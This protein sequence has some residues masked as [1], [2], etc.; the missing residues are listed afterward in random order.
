[1]GRNLGLNFPEITDR[2][3]LADLY[4]LSGISIAAA[5]L[6]SYHRTTSWGLSVSLLALFAAIAVAYLRN[7]L[8]VLFL[9][10]IGCFLWLSAVTGHWSSP[11]D[12]NQM[13]GATGLSFIVML[14][15]SILLLAR[16][17]RIAK[18]ESKFWNIYLVVG[19]FGAIVLALVLSS[20]NFASTIETMEKG[21]AFSA[22]TQFALWIGLLAV[23][24]SVSF[25]LYVRKQLGVVEILLALGFLIPV[26]VW[27]FSGNSHLIDAGDGNA[28]IR[29]TAL[30]WFWFTATNGLAICLGAWIF[31]L[32][33][34]LYNEGLIN[35]AAT[36]GLMFIVTKYIDWFFHVAS[37]GVF[38]FGLGIVVLIAGFLVDRT[39]RLLL[40]SIR[41]RDSIGN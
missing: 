27:S 21:R 37:I 33:W 34:R 38:L 12:G 11:D 22:W 4:A 18:S 40:E 6:F 2:V 25:L 29:L 10:L 36:Y 26:V 15:I 31:N 23:I 35:V 9:S 20:T 16:A 19:L 41:A 32:G 28:L 8:I 14:I 3:K 7:G 17:H 24:A 30:G 5:T 1:M 39:R 13:S